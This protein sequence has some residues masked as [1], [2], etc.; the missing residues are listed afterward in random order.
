MIIFLVSFLSS[1]CV[2]EILVPDLKGSLVGFVYTFDEFAKRLEDRSDV[3]VI[4]RG[5]KIYV[6]FTDRNGRFE[7]EDLPNGTYDLGFYKPGFGAMYYPG[8]KHLGGT[9]T[10]LGLSFSWAATSEA[11]F[12][13]EIPKTEIIDLKVENDSI[14]ARFRFFAPEPDYMRLFIYLCDKNGFT[15]EEAGGTMLTSLRRE[16]SGYRGLFNYANVAFPKGTEVFCKACILNRASS[17][18]DFNGRIF[19]PIDSYYDYALNKTVY[20]NMGDESAQFSFIVP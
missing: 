7:F 1:S 14:Y 16:A 5:L 13:Y 12:L 11:F 20:P 3:Q 2:K 19:G 9:P 18:T 10:T 4:A 15:V 6:T 17:T 8:V